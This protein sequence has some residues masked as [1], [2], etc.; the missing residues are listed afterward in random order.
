[1]NANACSEVLSTSCNP[2][3]QAQNVL[4]KSERGIY[5]MVDIDADFRNTQFL[6]GNDAGRHVVDTASFYITFSNSNP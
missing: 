3:I 1:M 2:S 4:A 6:H 5:N